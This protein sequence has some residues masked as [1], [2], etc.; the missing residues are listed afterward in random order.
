MSSRNG[1]VQAALGNHAA[2]A[3][4]SSRAAEIDPGY[5]PE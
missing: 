4:D 3:A 2:A 5:H 1:E